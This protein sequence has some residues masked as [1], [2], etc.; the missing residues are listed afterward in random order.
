MKEKRYIYAVVFP[1]VC[2]GVESLWSTRELAEAERDRYNRGG[3]F[4]GIL[5]EVQ[6]VPLDESPE[7]GSIWSWT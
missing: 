7:R 1:S 4:D 6:E 5:W 2:G 3:P